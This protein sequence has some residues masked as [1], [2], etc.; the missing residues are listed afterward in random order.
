MIPTKSCAAYVSIWCLLILSSCAGSQP[1]TYLVPRPPLLNLSETRDIAIVGINA[2]NKRLGSQ[3][4][5]LVSRLL[6]ADTTAVL[7]NSVDV[8]RALSGHAFVAGRIPDSLAVVVGK[9]LN[10]EAVLLADLKTRFTEEYGEEKLFR[11][12]AA[13]APSSGGTQ[14]RLAEIA[15]QEP[16]INQIVRL[17]AAIWALDVTTGRRIGSDRMAVMDTLHLVLPTIVENPP[18]G[19]QEVPRVTQRLLDRAVVALSREINDRL[20]WH[21]IPMTRYFARGVKGDKATLAGVMAGN[22]EGAKGFYEEA[23]RRNPGNARA[24]N[25]LAITYEKA[26]LADEAQEAFNNARR[27]GADDTTIRRNRLATP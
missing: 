9:K 21:T 13:Y 5:F 23:V 25:N 7:T 22:W 27:L 14:I 19:A 2:E 24:W 26:G 15:Y 16:Y 8:L 12:A 1:V 6:R 17:E 11:T 18:V 4:E 3:L 20:S 10:V